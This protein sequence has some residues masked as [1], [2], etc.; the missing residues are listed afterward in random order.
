MSIFTAIF[1]NGPGEYD[2]DANFDNDYA[3]LTPEQQRDWQSQ[4]QNDDGSDR[5][6]DGGP[7]L[8]DWAA[9]NGIMLESQKGGKS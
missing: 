7:A 3:A 8:H 2:D 9:D 5:T 6:D 1:G 4:H